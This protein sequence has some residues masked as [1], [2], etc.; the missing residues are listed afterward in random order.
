MGCMY[1]I[2]HDIPKIYPLKP[3]I[4]APPLTV[5]TPRMLDIKIR[6]SSEVATLKKKMVEAHLG[7]KTPGNLGI[8]MLIHELTTS[9]PILAL[10]V[11]MNS[12]E[13]KKMD[14]SWDMFMLFSPNQTSSAIWGWLFPNSNHQREGEGRSKF[15]QMDPI[16]FKQ[17]F[18]G[19][20]MLQFSNGYITLN[21]GG[22]CRFSLTI[23]LCS[24]PIYFQVC[25]FSEKH[26]WTGCDWILNGTWW[27]VHNR[28]GLW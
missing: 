19:L 17:T 8:N 26:K 16:G 9:Q 24:H 15:I 27:Q 20:D 5:S 25:L 1:I 3:Q 14:D 7:I 4:S 11:P 18:T 6:L 21:L 10:H 13:Q 28:R 23:K 2:S 22:C 12:W